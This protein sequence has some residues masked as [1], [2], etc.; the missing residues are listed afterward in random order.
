M[1]KGDWA[2]HY[3]ITQVGPLELTFHFQLIYAAS[4][5]L[6]LCCLGDAGLGCYGNATSARN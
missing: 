1:R 3:K 5:D 6:K 4:E 2:A